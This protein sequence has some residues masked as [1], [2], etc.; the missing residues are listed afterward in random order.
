MSR[1]NAAKECEEEEKA[2]EAAARKNETGGS[3]GA[4]GKRAR[5]GNPVYLAF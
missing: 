3:D 4:K 1:P 2:K 5:A